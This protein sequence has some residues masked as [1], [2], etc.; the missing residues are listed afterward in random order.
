MASGVVITRSKINGLVATDENSVGFSFSITDSTIDAGSQAGTGLGAVNFVATRVHILGGNRSVHCWKNG[1]IVDSYVHGQFRDPTGTA[2][3]SGIRMG[4]GATIRHN[5]ISCDAPDVA[6]DGG[7]SAG[8]TGYGD[9]APVK[10]NIIDN[11]YF[12]VTT[13][14]FCAYGGSSNGKPYSADASDIRFTN[15]VFEK[16]TSDPLCGF[17]G[18]ITSFDSDAPGNVWSGNVWSTGGTGTPAN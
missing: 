9:F 12:K 2:H 3:E 15:N 5:T 13:G 10:N 6:P 16:T 18:P 7:C 17:W 8:L 1:T 11:N 14:G 4:D